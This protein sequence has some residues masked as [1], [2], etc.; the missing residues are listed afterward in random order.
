M[1]NLDQ[2][3][4][5]S[6]AKASSYLVPISIIVAGALVAGA[7]WFQSGKKVDTTAQVG[8]K[9]AKVEVGN[10]PILGN[11]DAK[12]TLVEFGDYQCPFCQRLFKETEP[13]IRDQYIKAGQVKMAWRDF[14]FLGEESFWAAEAARCAN[15]QGKFWQFHDYLYN[16][17]NGE[18][19]GAFTKDKLKGFAGQMG[20]DQNQFNSCLDSDK[21]LQ[22]VKDDTDA[23]KAAGVDST[24]FV[25]VNGEGILGAQPFSVFKAAI[26]K[27]LK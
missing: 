17:Q 22:A 1:D 2:N 19:Q 3:Q 6:P 7:V 16:H 14:A 20:L 12:V 8:G 25:F 23:G 11:A 24:P 26:D 5:N 4:N 13:K 9:L 18:N 15:D 21:Y 10:L 27:Y